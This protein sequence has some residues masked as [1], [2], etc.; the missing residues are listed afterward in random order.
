MLVG[1]EA[2]V[3]AERGLQAGAVQDLTLDLG[4]MQG[5]ITI[6]S[7]KMLEPLGVGNMPHRADENAGLA[8]KF[9]LQRG[10][11]DGSNRKFGQSGSC[12]FHGVSAGM[13]DKMASYCSKIAFCE[14]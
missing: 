14:Q 4:G 7:T 10:S 8:K 11:A 12:Q 1:G 2:E 6:R 13:S 3:A 5:L 9:R